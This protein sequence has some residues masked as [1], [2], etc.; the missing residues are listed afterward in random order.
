[1][2]C[3]EW[4]SQLTSSFME[5]FLIRRLTDFF[6]PG[7]GILIGILSFVVLNGVQLAEAAGPPDCWTGDPDERLLRAVDRK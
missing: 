3:V 7:C 5:L 1:M 6:L 2:T 4:L